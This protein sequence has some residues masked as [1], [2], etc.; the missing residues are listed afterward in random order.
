MRASY[1]C[2]DNQDRVTLVTPDQVSGD[3]ISW[4][5]RMSRT[6]VQAFAVQHGIRLHYARD[7]APQVACRRPVGHCGVG[8][9]VCGNF[10]KSA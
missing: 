3:R 5:G 10:K 9:P 4:I 1:L 7:D 8:S 2:I 6:A